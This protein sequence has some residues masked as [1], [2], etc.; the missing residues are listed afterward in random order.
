[1][2]EAKIFELIKQLRQEVRLNDQRI[3]QLTRS[4]DKTILNETFDNL[5]LGTIAGQG[6]YPYATAWSIAEADHT[7][8][9]VE[10]SGADRMVKIIAPSGNLSTHIVTT[11]TNYFK[12]NP[13]VRLSWDM[14]ID[15]DVSGVAG[16]VLICAFTS[17]IRASIGFHY[18][19]GLHISAYNGL[20]YSN[21]LGATKN[22]WYHIDMI[23]LPQNPSGMILV[24]ID[25]AY[26]GIY[27]SSSPAQD[28][29]M[30]KAF[31]TSAAES[32]TN[33]DIDNLKVEA[34]LLLNS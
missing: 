9:V 31:A 1:M 34:L 25:G 27:A 3:K 4:A 2:I 28:L 22:T 29:N 30:I 7:A 15:N 19:S 17:D 24:Y 18:D 11:V 16:G 10:K 6:S 33:I 32:A 26:E 20:D 14:R 12:M 5:S 21:I 13:G 8:D 23:Y